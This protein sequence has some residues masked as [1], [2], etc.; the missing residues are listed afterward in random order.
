MLT[1][2]PLPRFDGIYA[3]LNGS[4]IYSTFDMISGYHHIKSSKES[5]PKSAFVTL[6]GIFE[7]K[8]VHFG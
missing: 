2:E 8:H 6:I 7:F 4:C 5:Q 3:R 1:L